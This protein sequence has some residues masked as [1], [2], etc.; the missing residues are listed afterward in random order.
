M[1]VDDPND[2]LPREPFV[3]GPDSMINGSWPIDLTLPANT[4]SL[5]PPGHFLGM[6]TVALVA[7]GRRRQL[8]SIGAIPL[9]HCQGLVEPRSI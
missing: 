1:W 3:E 7:R 9:C 5:S 6:C 4:N 8:A 2:G